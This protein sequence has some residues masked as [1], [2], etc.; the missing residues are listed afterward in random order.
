MRLATPAVAV[1]LV[2][3]ACG[4]SSSETADGTSATWIDGVEG[5]IDVTSDN[6]IVTLSGAITEIVYALGLGD[7]VVAVD[8]TAVYPPEATKLP[9]VGVGRFL[10]AEAVLAQQPTLVIGD[11]QTSPPEAIQQIRDAGVPVLI[12]DVPTS[13]EGLYAKIIAMGEA[14]G[15]AQAGRSLAAS[16]EDDIAAAQ[17]LPKADPAPQVAFVYSRGPDVILLFGSEMTTQPLIEAAGG[18][19]VGAA[20]GI[21]GTV[22]FTPEALVAAEPD[23]IVITS[24][25][26]DLLGGIDG[27]LE[28]PGF[29]ATPA[30]R[31]RRILDYPE[32]D[33]LTFGP[34]IFETLR[35]LNNDLRSAASLCN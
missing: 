34:R 8:V 15:V 6:R 31:E 9:V 30:G 5:V 27:L 4:S 2:L 23:V 14:L 11:I 16:V 22:D 28:I 33:I 18:V 35:C 7:S 3:A 20:S 19:D 26:L 25:G 13:F 1:L 17:G 21:V 12:T 24:E 10:T 32:G 29:A